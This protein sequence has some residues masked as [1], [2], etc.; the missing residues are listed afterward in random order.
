MVIRDINVGQ[1]GHHG[2][3][4]VRQEF[5]FIAGIFTVKTSGSVRWKNWLDFMSYK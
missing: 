5:D 1:I 2:C 4:E 3:L